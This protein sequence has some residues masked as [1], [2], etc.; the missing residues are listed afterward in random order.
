MSVVTVGK[1]ID[2]SA[3]LWRY[4]SLE[5]FIDLLDTES[6]FFSPVAYYDKTDPFE[7]LLPEVALKAFAGVNDKYLSQMKHNKE[8]IVRMVEAKYGDMSVEKQRILDAMDDSIEDFKFSL[9]R[10]FP[11][12][13]KS[14]TVSCWHRG[15]HESEAMWRLYSKNGIAIKSSVNSIKRSFE[16]NGQDHSIHVAPV[17]YID[18]YD[19]DLTPADCVIDGY[20][21]PFI[22][23]ASFAHENEIRFCITANLDVRNP[24]KHVPSPIK[25]KTNL[26][27]LIEKIYISPFSVEPFI[28]SVYA[29]CKKYNIREEVILR[30]NL[31]NGHD[32][33]LNALLL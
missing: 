15:E 21:M 24:E 6:L 28:S 31:L 10:N 16:N 25:V 5:A 17:K 32:D 29:V 27:F 23:R 26:N 30:S 3:A 8:K 9:R 11:A 7:G 14:V 1:S 12:I 4:I 19:K 33:L 2:E 20:T 13:A 22:K 18:F